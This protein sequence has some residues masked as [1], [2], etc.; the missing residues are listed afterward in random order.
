MLPAAAPKAKAARI[1]SPTSTPVPTAPS[2]GN[3]THKAVPSSLNPRDLSK[4]RVKAKE[5]VLTTESG[6]N[7]VE[8][9]VAEVEA[10]LA[11]PSESVADMVA[12]AAEHT[13]LQ[14]ELMSALAAWEAAVAAQDALGV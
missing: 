14:D 3:G 2:N 1:T 13:R 6:V 10:R 8:T 7:T 4:A 11:R 9:R 5:L 12:L